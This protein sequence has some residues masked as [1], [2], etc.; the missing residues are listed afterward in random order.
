MQ[1]PPSLA[2]RLRALLSRPAARSGAMIAIGCTAGL[3]IG[4]LLVPRAPGP[5]DPKA[6]APEVRLLGEVLALDDEAPRRALERVRRYAAGPITFKLADGK[7]RELY[8]GRLGAEIDKVRLADMVRDA[9]DATSPLRRVWQRAGAGKPLELPVPIAIRAEAALEQLF[10]LKDEFDRLPVDARL[11][12]EKRQLI[13]EVN[14]RL[15]DVD[16]TFAALEAAVQRGERGVALV[17]DERKPRRVASQLGNVR[18]DEVLGWFE[19]RYNRSQRYQ[20]RTFNLRLA[21]SKLDGYVLLPGEEFDFNDVVGPRDEANGYKVAP[22]IAEGELVDGIGGGTCQISGTLHGAAF[23]A[24]L[25]IVERYPHTRPSSYIK[26][27][28]DATVVYPTINFRVRNAYDFPIVMHETV[29]NGVVRA[30]VLGA[31][32]SRTVTL[33]R[34]ID[35][36]IPYEEVERPDKDVPQGVRVLGQRGV[37][38]FRL[39]RYRIVRDGTHAMRE[40]WNDVYPPTQQIIRVGTQPITPD[41]VK[42][43]DEPHPEYVADELLVLTQ[44]LDAE[45]EPQD[46]KGGGLLEQREPGKYGEYGWTE[47]MG[48]PF[49]HGEGDNKGQRDGEGETE[50]HRDTK[51]SPPT[52]SRSKKPEPPKRP[53]DPAR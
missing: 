1:P 36:A 12:L 50:S 5:G 37:P 21:A 40:R 31:K 13:P 16:A 41:S 18:F 34:R 9:R 44:G 20:A 42:P 48:M 8:L 7:A 11:D 49:W 38:G 33:I 53:P 15:L 2:E 24:G 29:K 25:D 35:A 46:E 52:T 32:R 4:F 23:F 28:L 17:F 27:G 10:V 43:E 47:K 19:T 45:A 14:G 22:V 39:H 6:P 26:M 51:A 30:E 3:V